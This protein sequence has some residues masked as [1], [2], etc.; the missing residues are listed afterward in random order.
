MQPIFLYH[1]ELN[2]TWETLYPQI[3][4]AKDYAF[5]T[6]SLYAVPLEQSVRFSAQVRMTDTAAYQI[7]RYAESKGHTTNWYLDM[8]KPLK[9][10][11]FLCRE[12][13]KT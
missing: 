8:V 12:G 2:E 9:K 7:C 4:Q 11:T 1:A 13:V 3:L 10:E 5:E 6:E